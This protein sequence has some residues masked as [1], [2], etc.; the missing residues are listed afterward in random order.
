MDGKEAEFKQ[1]DDG[2]WTAREGDYE[3]HGRDKD[4]AASDLLKN[5]TVSPNVSNQTLANKAQL[6]DSMSVEVDR[7]KVT[8]LKKKTPE[9]YSF[10]AFYES[11]PN[12]QG[13]GKTNNEARLDLF[14]KQKAAQDEGAK[15]P[16]R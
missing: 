7:I 10:V 2:S 5:K 13:F 1:E 6:S 11:N 15:Q 12:M 3:G 9:G 14:K 8:Q 4:E 16:Q